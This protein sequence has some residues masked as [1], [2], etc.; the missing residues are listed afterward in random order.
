MSALTKGRQFQL[1]EY[2]VS[3]GSLLIRSPAGPGRETSIDIIC[4]GLEYLA[5][6]R[7]LGEITVSGAT[8]DEVDCLQKV[9][10]RQ[11]SP[12]CVWALETL[13]ARF[14]IVAASL[15]V[16]EHPG[17][18]F[19]SPFDYGGMTVN[20]RLFAA[21]LHTKWDDAVRNRERANMIE[22]LS[23]VDLGQQAENIVDTVLSNPS[24]YGLS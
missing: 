10:Q 18:I 2:R 19:E 24:K 3:H 13:S 17:D 15:K 4:T 1:W 7:H 9:L 8:R 22:L 5:A 12:S 16:Q 14:L 11:L 6:P 20:E 21:G 23:R